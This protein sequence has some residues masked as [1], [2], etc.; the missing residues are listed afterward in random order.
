MRRSPDPL[1]FL[2]ALE[3]KPYD[4]GFFQVLRELEC[5]YPNAARIGTSPRPQDEPFRLG[6][7]PAMAFPPSVFSSVIPASEGRPPRLIQQFF[8]LFGPNGALPLHLTEFAR[9]RLLNMRDSALVRFFDLLH[10]RPLQMFYRAWAQAQPTVGFDR[11]ESDRFSAYVGSLVGMGTPAVRRR[12]AAGD[13]ARLF[14]AGWLSRQVRSADGLRSI[15][16]GYYR[17][18][19]RIQEFAGHWLKLPD[20]ELTR[21]G[22]RT[23]GCQLGRG[24]VLG[25]RV[26]DRQHCIQIEFGPLTIEQFESFL[27]GGQALNQLVALV[28]HYLTFEISWDLR[29][30]LARGQVPT[31]QLGGKSRLGWTTWT[32]TRHRAK[33]ATDVVLDVESIVRRMGGVQAAGAMRAA[34]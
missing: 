25:A 3:E 4:Y 16:S 24:S 17:L 27:P 11:P 21:I 22:T 2:R 6:Q 34:A 9:D 12:D 7:D 18:P 33:D 30:V 28:R 20:D 1:S 10:H 26:W 8:G 32:A 23:S 15:L 19:V 13:H 5:R 31:A 14:F 29:L